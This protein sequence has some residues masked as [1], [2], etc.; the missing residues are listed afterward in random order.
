MTGARRLGRAHHPHAPDQEARRDLRGRRSGRPH[1]R[2]RQC[3]RSWRSSPGWARDIGV[4]IRL[5][6]R[7][8]HAKSDLSSKFGVGPFEAS[9][10]V[11]QALAQGT[12]VAGF[13]FHV[14]SQLDD[15]QRFG[16]AVAD[17]LTL[18]D[19][20]QHVYPVRFD[21][22][23]IGGGFPIAYEKS[24]ASIET[25]AAILRPLLEAAPS[26]PRHHRGAGPGARRRGDDR[27]DERRRR[28]RAHRRPLVLPRRRRL[29]RLL[30]RDRRR[31]AP[32]AAR[33]EGALRR[34]GRRHAPLGH[35]R[36]TDLRLGRCHRA[37]GAASR[38][39]RR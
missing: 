9:H 20:L 35:P 24:V 4:L 37:R 13:S 32:A 22:L 28:R 6:Y 16:D 17:T 14:G 15:P 31:R 29:R 39:R 12:R 3:R 10:L 11:E 18:M 21:T 26:R 5:A 36:R 1:V 2:R 19:H 23:D 8:P 30:Q 34:P 33:R 38:S 7:S 27:R 25:I